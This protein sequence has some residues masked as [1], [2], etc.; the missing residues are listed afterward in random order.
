MAEKAPTWKT[1]LPAAKS[2]RALGEDYPETLT[3]TS[4][5][6]ASANKERRVDA[7]EIG[8]Q[9]LKALHLW[10]GLN[11]RNECLK[12]KSSTILVYIPY[13]ITKLH[14][15]ELT[16]TARC[17]LSSR[18]SVSDKMHRFIG[19]IRGWFKFKE[20]HAFSSVTESDLIK[21]GILR[22]GFL[23]NKPIDTTTATTTPSE[24]DF[25]Q[26][27]QKTQLLYPLHNE[28]VVRIWIDTYFR[29][30]STLVP[31]DHT[32]VLRPEQFVPPV[33]LSDTSTHSLHG[34]VD[35]AVII[36]S[37]KDAYKFRK[38]KLALTEC[39]HSYLFV[40][41][42]K[43]PK[44]HLEKHIPQVIAEMYACAR[45]SRKQTIRGAI[46]NGIA[47]CFLILTL[48]SVEGDQGAKGGMF[49]QSKILVLGNIE[50]LVQ[51][52]V[53]M[54]YSVLSHWLHNSNSPWGDDDKLY[55]DQQLTLNHLHSSS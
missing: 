48:N 18:Y 2:K 40:S 53:S 4:G 38:K 55:F 7:E 28:A 19:N 43:G 27:I 25:F 47:W 37:K 35:W 20:D 8:A 11:T 32:M 12:I 22:E 45:Q 24:D 3:G 23:L 49:W 6:T 54:V 42:A 34:R 51:S 10:V 9:N 13:S 30:I 1:T 14:I 5:G 16:H 52:K 26:N 36:T 21:M 46:T 50:A 41:E 29:H 33:P 15:L 39:R 17:F 44:K 31:P